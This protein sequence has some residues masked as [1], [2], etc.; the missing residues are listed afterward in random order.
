M[1]E[2]SVFEKSYPKVP[3]VVIEDAV[4]RDAGV[5]LIIKREDLIHPEI[6]GNKWRKLKYNLIEA[7]KQ[8]LSTL[9]TFGGAYSNHIY[10]TAAAGILF[11]FKTIGII[12]GEQPTKLN[13]TLLKAVE[14]NMQLFFVNRTAYRD[15]KEL[16]AQLS[17]DLESIYVIP[18]GGTNSLALKG[19]SEIVNE[20]DEKY[21]INYWCTSCGTGGTLGGIIT[22]L[23]A[24]QRAIGFSALKGDFLQK[25][26]ERLL[27]DFNNNKYQNWS[28]N[29]DYH[30]GGYAKFDETLVQFINEFKRKNKIQLDPIYTGK[31]FYG[32]YDLIKKGYFPKGSTIMALHTG[33]QQG[34]QGFNQRF[35][36][37]I[38]LK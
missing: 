3:T 10:A 25:E 38:D 16:L 34:I 24:Q 9:L 26:V 22:A 2:L 5:R 15:K 31:M 29:T 20:Y 18:E 7:K 6:S 30:F 32:I 23:S 11:G 37:L 36:N 19:C 27:S 4:I 14:N 8:M 28:I 1:T 12:R 35:G 21:K 33:G 17:L 13:P